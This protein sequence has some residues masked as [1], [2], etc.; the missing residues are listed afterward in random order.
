MGK[1]IYQNRKTSMVNYDEEEAIE[2][3]GF[4]EYQED[5]DGNFEAF[6]R[7]LASDYLTAMIS[8]DFL[9]LGELDYWQLCRI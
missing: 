8:E 5:I 1:K 2:L 9:S 3:G 7:C 6:N 4:S